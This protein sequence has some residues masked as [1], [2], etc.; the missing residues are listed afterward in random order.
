MS[1][2]FTFTGNSSTLT[3]NFYPELEFDPAYSYS[4]GLLEFTAY[5]SIPNISNENNKLYFRTKSD[6]KKCAKA[7]KVATEKE[8]YYVSVSSG[9]YEFADI[10]EYLM[11]IFKECS[12]SFDIAVDEKTLRTSVKSSVE[13]LFNRDDSIHRIFGFNDCIIKQSTA[14][15][16]EKTVSI[17]SLNVIAVECD[18]V[19]GSYINGKP[20][21]SIHEFSPSSNHGYKIVEVPKNIVYLPIDRNNIQ[22]IQIRIVDQD[23]KLINFRGEKITCRIHIK[24][25]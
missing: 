25:D 3:S 15:T 12:I 20:G 2:T 5:N 24:R 21:H 7:N 4:C 23:R 9:A 11:K 14:T 8:V 16:S 6:L 22:S 19:S 10:I 1:A 13:L 18:I 17:S